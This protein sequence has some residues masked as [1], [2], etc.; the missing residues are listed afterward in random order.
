[1]TIEE[2][3]KNLILSKYKSI[4]EFCISVDMPYSTI[5]SILRRGISKASI[6]NIIKI[7]RHFNISADALAD[8]E[9]VFNGLSI[10]SSYSSEEQNIIKKYRVLN[11]HDKM[12]VDTIVDQ[13][14]DAAKPKEE[15]GVC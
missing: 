1:M 9:I 8:E 7:C 13:L 4:R 5:D 2:K 11:E 10:T 6:A 15:D 14:Y 12:V 3:L